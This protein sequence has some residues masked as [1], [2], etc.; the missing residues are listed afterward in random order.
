M[1]RIA[2]ALAPITGDSLADH[3]ALAAGTAAA[4]FIRPSDYLFVYLEYGRGGVTRQVCIDR[5]EFDADGTIRPIQLTTSGVTAATASNNELVDLTRREGVVVSSSSCRKAIDIRGISDSNRLLRREDYSPTN[6][7]DGSNFTRWLP[8]EDD[9]DP[10]LMM[11][12]KGIHSIRRTELSLYRPTLGH[13]YTLEAS[14][15][16]QEWTSVAGHAERRLRSPHIDLVRVDARYLRL[17][18]IEGH[19]GTWEL[20]I[21]GE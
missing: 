19:P 5:M 11:D 1:Q 4:D 20:R 21:F 6:A 3:Q 12:L 9:D 2:A 7:T 10:W 15:D 13:A 18:F 8:D 17:R 16:G 14:V